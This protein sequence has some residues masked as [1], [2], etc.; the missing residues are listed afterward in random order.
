MS[1]DIEIR[2][3]EKVNE[4]GPMMRPDLDPCWIWTGHI[5]GGYGRFKVGKKTLC[6]H[7]VSWTLIFGDPK[8]LFVLHHCDNPSCVRPSH[9]FLGT[10]KDNAQDALSKNR[11]YITYGE[12]AGNSKL[13]EIAVRDIRRR[14]AS[15][16]S[17]SALAKEF[18]IGLSQVYNIVKG[19]Q[20]QSVLE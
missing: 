17:K 14:R 5:V 2:F 18:G 6:A 10:K 9:L 15:G 8:E 16:E 7:R 11:L 4:A 12:N 3:W 20:W 19:R 13:T 1:R